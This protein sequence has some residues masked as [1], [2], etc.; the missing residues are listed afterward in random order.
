MYPAS[1]MTPAAS[2]ISAGVQPG[3]STRQTADTFGL[4]GRG[5]LKPGAFADIVVFDPKHYAARATYEQPTLLAAGGWKTAA[6][7]QSLNDRSDGAFFGPTARS[8][9]PLPS[10]ATHSFAPE[11][12]V[13]R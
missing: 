12:P 6:R 8:S 5:R 9:V 3:R 7:S 13:S 1:S 10:A 2:T 4:T 11:A